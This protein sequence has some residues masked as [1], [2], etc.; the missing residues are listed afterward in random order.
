MKEN[1]RFDIDV[2]CKYL[3]L[4]AV[5]AYMGMCIWFNLKHGVK[6]DLPDWIVVSTT[7]IIQYFFRRSPSKPKEAK[8]ESN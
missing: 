5:T 2:M 4:F 3:V 6:I 1:T 8:N 7:L